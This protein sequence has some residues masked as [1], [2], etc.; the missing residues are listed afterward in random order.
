[1]VRLGD[2]EA[3]DIVERDALSVTYGLREGD[4]V[5]RLRLLDPGITLGEAE[6][7]RLDAAFTADAYL[8]DQLASQSRSWAK[9]SQ[10]GLSQ[11]GGIGAVDARP[12][13]FI[14]TH[15]PALD[16]E[17]ARVFGLRHDAITLWAFADGIV[18]GLESLDHLAGRPHGN[19][20]ES[21]I[22]V[23]L[24]RGRERLR[25]R[26]TDPA[27]PRGGD[28]SSSGTKLSTTA[29]PRLDAA[30][31]NQDFARDARALG[32]I[33]FAAV[34]GR[35]PKPIERSASLDELP[36]WARLGR[37]SRS[38]RL[39]V[40]ELLATEATDAWRPGRVRARLDALRPLRSKLGPNV[41]RGV[42]ATLVAGI[43]VGGYA[44]SGVVREQL[45]KW[46]QEELPP[47]PV[48]D[49]VTFRDL[50]AF[51]GLDD[52]FEGF[53]GSDVDYATIRTEIARELASPD[54]LD[55]SGYA[56]LQS[57]L[58]EL[59]RSWQ[60]GHRVARHLRA[61]GTLQVDASEQRRLGEH[62]AD[63]LVVI[64]AGF[65]SA[66]DDSEDAGADVAQALAEAA[67]M[68]Q[69]VGTVES[70]VDLAGL[71]N[72]ARAAAIDPRL[73]ERID[74]LL[75]EAKPALDEPVDT[76]L[77]SSLSDA[78]QRGGDFGETIAP[79]LPIVAEAVVALQ[80]YS[81]ASA[82][83]GQIDVVASRLPPELPSEGNVWLEQ[84]LAHQPLD[85]S[86]AAA[87]RERQAALRGLQQ[88]IA[89][90]GADGEEAAATLL[91][92]LNDAISAEAALVEIASRD[93]AI[94]S[95]VQ[96]RFPA[97]VASMAERTNV[98][99]AEFASAWETFV[100]ERQLES[101][102]PLVVALEQ[103]IKDHVGRSDAGSFAKVRRA[104]AMLNTV[105]A[106]PGV[107]EPLTTLDLPDL[108]N[109]SDSPGLTEH[110]DEHRQDF[111]ALESAREDVLVR[112]TREPELLDDAA[113]SRRAIES[114]AT[115]ET[116]MSDRLGWLV[117]LDALAG[118]IATTWQ[119]ADE[120]VADEP[121]L[122]DRL[123][124]EAAR[125]PSQTFPL[126][127]TQ[128]ALAA[129]LDGTLDRSALADIVRDDNDAVLRATAY[130][131]LGSRDDWG[132]VPGDV[133]QEL[134]FHDLLTTVELS[135]AVSS[136]RAAWPGVVD[137]ALATVPAAEVLEVGEMIQTW[138]GGS[139]QD[140]GGD[141]AS[142][143]E[144]V[145]LVLAR[146][147]ENAFRDLADIGGRRG[148]ALDDLLDRVASDAAF[149]GPADGWRRVTVDDDVRR[150]RWVAD[151][152]GPTLTFRKVPNVGS[153]RGVAVF[154]TTHEMTVD[155]TFRELEA[156]DDGVAFDLLG[157]AADG[158]K[159]WDRNATTARPRY[160]AGWVPADA[161]QG[162]DGLPDDANAVSDRS[163]MQS[164]SPVAAWAVAS[165]LN[166]RLPTLT[167]WQQAAATGI[168]DR[169]NLRD[170]T[171]RRHFEALRDADA[172]D[173]TAASPLA[174][175][176]TDPP[177]LGVLLENDDALFFR[178][179]DPT[180]A[181][182]GDLRG[183]VAEWIVTPTPTDLSSLTFDGELPRR[184]ADGFAE[185]NA[186]VAA[187]GGSALSDPEIPANTPRRIDP[188]A[189]DTN[190]A[191]VG[192]RVVF[193]EPLEAHELVAS[194]IR[195]G[196]LTSDALLDRETVGDDIDAVPR[197]FDLELTLADGVPARR[198]L[199]AIDGSTNLAA[200]DRQERVREEVSRLLRR[201]P[202]DAEVEV[203]LYRTR[204]V[205]PA[206]RLRSQAGRAAAD[207]AVA[208][209]AEVLAG[210][211][212][213]RARPVEVL[214]RVAQRTT[215]ETDGMIPDAVVLVASGNADFLHEYDSS[216]VTDPAVALGIPVFGIALEGGGDDVGQRLERLAEATGGRS[217]RVVIE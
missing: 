53:T 119:S 215:G 89:E 166:A 142:R 143:A 177:A 60:D 118:R 52:V 36:E 3:T 7:R 194:A 191:D 154:M 24:S 160:D 134:A 73:S 190:V 169:P 72:L 168:D 80:P 101:S 79:T 30:R 156:I 84:L 48:L 115:I 6:E 20:T 40:G 138:P 67:A 181:T 161:V 69:A 62:F 105:A 10:I 111:A 25:I 58:S 120:S 74:M 85:D 202:Q 164:I 121:P 70:N 97:D 78:R 51:D 214:Q 41:R 174:G 50:M 87:A 170:L 178:P 19:L 98:F 173:R 96:G 139:L 37:R 165:T 172:E 150:F 77:A 133:R 158:P 83:L 116:R 92:D 205:L 122:V 18:S 29:N 151:A 145:R 213:G 104:T 63:L 203:V 204:D 54:G 4:G 99:V 39:L 86:V 201:L 140:I 31:L 55:I 8:R 34:V 176:D 196:G 123:A 109:L 162:L 22:G 207:T 9:V 65:T 28:Q 56:R 113:D 12:R 68:V 128:Q 206:T 155:A 14:A 108:P 141:G 38:W 27:L 81:V 208:E 217:R 44:S 129:I 95:D 148:R 149:P 210:R 90:F 199:I 167:E 183:N 49:G 75:A 5:V 131:A 152:D 195:A 33:L 47:G 179:A 88:Q 157:D 124:T 209:L 32:A 112:W 103:A 106:V 2:Y 211:M 35:M 159:A 17:A 137:R 42:I 102:D 132:S 1:M 94:R 200:G 193:E 197:L 185:A 163:P 153:E 23:D 107:V 76:L 11:T 59:L 64:N 187:I 100:T 180:A 175:L 188:A 147:D 45:A 189:W 192:F 182:F 212:S 186:R 15:H 171:W 126:R 117:D 82:G 57:A 91:S 144:L 114:V 93:D 26:L 184:V 135:P 130:V 110:V 46:F 16:A 216:R 127:E 125:Y 198:I 13:P 71:N 136:R 61:A 66:S 43:A 146:A 21:A